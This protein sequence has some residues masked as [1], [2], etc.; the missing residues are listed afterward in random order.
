MWYNWSINK[1]ANRVLS[2]PLALALNRRAS[3]SSIIPQK[4]CTKC[5]QFYPAT[6]E[7]FHRDKKNKDGF[8]NRCKDCV[9]V[10]SSLYY[11]ENSEKIKSYVSDWQRQNYK[12]WA[13]CL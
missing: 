9:R 13:W 5:E 2:A 4:Q 1:V 10:K 12:K 11:A 8:V 6:T 3:M 7:Y